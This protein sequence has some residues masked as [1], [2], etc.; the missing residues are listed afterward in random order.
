MMEFLYSLDTLVIAIF[1]FG[2]FLVYELI[3]GKIPVR[4]FG[5]IKRSERPI[6][7]WLFMLLHVV[8][9]GVL[10]YAWVDGLRISVSEMFD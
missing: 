4:W 5:S 2:A 8:I 3:S 1:I 10:T 6:F 7:Y 9:L